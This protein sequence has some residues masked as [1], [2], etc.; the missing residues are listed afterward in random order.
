[1]FTNR[2]RSC[3]VTFSTST[4]L[5]RLAGGA[6]LFF[7]TPFSQIDLRRVSLQTLPILSEP[8]PSLFDS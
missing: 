4:H 2:T 8:L 6:F 1:M 5:L 3:A 7:H